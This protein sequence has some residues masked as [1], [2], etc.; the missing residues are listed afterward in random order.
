[1]EFIKYYI[2]FV[3]LILLQIKTGKI[4][5]SQHQKLSPDYVTQSL[6][7]SKL[8][9]LGLCQDSCVTTP[10][11]FESI[12]PQSGLLQSLIVKT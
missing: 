6:D 8:L 5:N 10:R 12:H 1:M 7:L 4:L 2:V 3:L 9:S 11:H